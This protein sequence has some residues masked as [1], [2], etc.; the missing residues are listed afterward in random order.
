MGKEVGMNTAAAALQP[1]MTLQH[2]LVQAGVREE[3]PFARA[4]VMNPEMIP[5]KHQ[6]TGLNQTL[7]YDRFAVYDEPGCGKT[8]I[9]HAV[10]LYMAG[11]QNKV[12]IAMPPVLLE[13][14]E[15]ELDYTF[16][17]W[18][19]QVSLHVLRENPAGREKLFKKWRAEGWPDIICMSYQTLAKLPRQRKRK[20]KTDKPKEFFGNMTEP[21]EWYVVPPNADDYISGVLKKHGYN[22]VI[23]DE[24]HALKNPTSNQ[25]KAV[26][27]LLGEDGGLMLMTGTPIPNELS[28]AFG[29]IALTSP[30]TYA[31]KKSFE[32]LHCLYRTNDDGYSTLIGYQNQ[33]TISTHLYSRA[34]RVT[35]EQVLNLKKPQVIEVPINLDESHHRLYKKLIRERFLEM[36]DEVIT[37]LNQQALRQKSMQIITTPEHFTKQKFPI[38]IVAGVDQLIDNIGIHQEK[39]VVFATY[40]RSV[41]SLRDH[42]IAKGLNPA[43]IY[44][45]KGNNDEQKRKFLNDDTCR[46]L[47]ANPVSGGYGLNLQTV[48]RWVIFAEPTSVPGDF[49]QASERVHRKGQKKVVTI[50]ILKALGTISPKLTKKMLSKEGETMGV[51]KDATSLLDELMGAAA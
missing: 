17:G 7:A 10:A 46:V 4:I 32:R 9:A 16:Y 35:K 11:Y 14:F 29:M 25:H 18:R 1:T 20:N 21:G 39:V 12:V 5:M 28:D 50:Y 30:G 43:V 48:C 40:Q 42:F 36:G 26:Q 2:Y 47:V 15:E 13:Q 37:A 45:G 6:V 22:Y 38:E 27:Y 23:A 41:E 49:K 8:L 31:S 19:D 51:M 34:R 33:E 24:A 44:G 3:L